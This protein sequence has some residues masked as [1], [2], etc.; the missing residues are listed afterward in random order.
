MID[1]AEL[2][3]MLADHRKYHS[4]FQIAHFILGANSRGTPYGYYVQAVRELYSRVQNLR[5]LLPQLRMEQR[6]YDRLMQKA[7][8]LPH[9]FKQ[10]DC[11]DRAELSSVEI[12]GLKLAVNETWRELVAF[13]QHARAARQLLPNELTEGVRHQLDAESWKNELEQRIETDHRY[14][15]MSSRTRELLESMP[16]T[17]HA[18]M[19]PKAGLNPR[20]PRMGPA[21][22]REDAHLNGGTPQPHKMLEILNGSDPAPGS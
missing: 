10:G 2:K 17:I 11:R 19:A 6:K 8:S 18:K 7:L 15:G 14:G 5:R 13:Y 4:P 3:N 12:D 22:I 20:A 21:G 1:Q 9:S 16:D